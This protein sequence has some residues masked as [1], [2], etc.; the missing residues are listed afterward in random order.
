MEDRITILL[1]DYRNMTGTF[2]TTVSI[3]MLEAV[4]HRHLGTFFECCDHLLKEKG[5][6]ALQTITIPDERYDD[7]GGP[8]Y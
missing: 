5:C 8:V 2:D 1:R 7:T 3:E 6:I 4:G